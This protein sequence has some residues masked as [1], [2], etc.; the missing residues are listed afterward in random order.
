MLRYRFNWTRGGLLALIS[1]FFLAHGLSVLAAAPI[2]DLCSGALVVP[3]G[4]PFPIVLPVVADISEAANDGDPPFPECGVVLSR[5][6]WYSFRPAQT[7]EYTLSVSADTLTTVADT[8][9]AVYESTAGCMGTLTEVDCD[10]DQDEETRSA[11]FLTLT[12]GTQYYIVVWAYG[13]QVPN[14]GHTSVQLRVSRPIPPA[15]DM[16]ATA[17]VIPANGPFP[18]F[19][20]ITD[21][22]K[23]GTEATPSAPTCADY[24]SKSVWYRFTPAETTLYRISSCDETATTAGTVLAIYIASNCVGPFAQIACNDDGGCRPGD[25]KSVV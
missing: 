13:A 25:R 4:G 16:C 5:S 9:M 15:N 19:T 6:I 20:G 18:H 17:E 21:I 1:T 11:M 12:G 14:P 22:T 8:V 23:A 7:A 24:V 2:N 3:S 10:D